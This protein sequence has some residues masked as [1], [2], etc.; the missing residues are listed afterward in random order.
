M[1]TEQVVNKI[2]SEAEKNAEEIKAENDKKIFAYNQKTDE[3]VQHHEQHSDELAQ[4]AGEE[5]KRRILAT[6]RMKSRTEILSKKQQIVS[7]LNDR[8]HDKMENLS[9]EQFQ[10]LYA[11]LIKK[12]AVN[13]D[14]VIFPG[15]EEKLVDEDFV[16]SINKDAGLKLT[17][18]EEKA[19]FKRGVSLSSGQVSINL[20]FE[21]LVEMAQ[22]ELEG[23]IHSQLFT[24]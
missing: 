4:K 22:S 23:E 14:E 21:V 12:N 3:L 9:K 7:K 13:G 16:N 8:V 2:I 19:S 15:S 20:S 10:K 18:A 17:L 24:E 1:N 6:A 5:E 11:G